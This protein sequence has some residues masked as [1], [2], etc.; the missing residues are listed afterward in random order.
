MFK[1]GVISG[2]YFPVV[3]LNTEIY[4]V[5]LRSQSKYKKMRIR[6]NSVFGHFTCSDTQKNN[7]LPKTEKVNST[8]D[9]R[10]LEL[11]SVLSFSLRWKFAQ[12]GDFQSQA[13]KMNITTE[14]CRLKIKLVLVPNLSFSRQF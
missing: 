9:F 2:P 1:Y 13:D 3:G 4:S 11:V 12:K 6:S 5:N 14:F 10:I 7:F 8:I